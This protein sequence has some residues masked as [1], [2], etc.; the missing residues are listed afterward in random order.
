MERLLGMLNCHSAHLSFIGRAEVP[1]QPYIVIH[2][3]RD[4]QDNSRQV[5]HHVR[6][7]VEYK[8]EGVRDEVWDVRGC[9][10]IS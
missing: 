9:D 7:G 8:I 10:N 1:S 3:K 2:C 6:K 4:V 5:Y